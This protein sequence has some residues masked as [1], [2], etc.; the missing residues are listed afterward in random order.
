MKNFNLSEA[1][2]GKPVCLEDGSPARIVCYDLKN[3]EYPLLVAYQV[4]TTKE[5]FDAFSIE[6]KSFSCPFDLKMQSITHTKWVNVYDTDDE[7]PYAEMS[8]IGYPTESEA[9]GA[10]N[11]EKKYHKTIQ[12]T[13]ED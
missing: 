3:E 11:E 4:D 10:I 2:Q 1:R 8:K 13:W 9:K 5:C 6:G 12:I 7:N